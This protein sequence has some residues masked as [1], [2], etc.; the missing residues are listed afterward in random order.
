MNCTFTTFCD[1]GYDKCVGRIMV[2][3]PPLDVRQGGNT[4]ILIFI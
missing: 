2:K 1:F 3:M 4:E